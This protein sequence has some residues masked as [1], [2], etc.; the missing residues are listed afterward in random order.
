MALP[1]AYNVRNVRARLRVALLAVGSIA[2]VVAVV[3]VLLAMAQG[4]AAALRGTGRDDNAIVVSRGSNSEV[5]SRVEL[6]ERNAILDHVTAVRGPDGRALASWEWV[7]VMA[8]PRKSDGR[9]SNVVLRMVPPQALQVR[10]GVHVIAGREVQSGLEEVMVGRR[11]VERV[12]GLELGG[13]LEVPALQLKI[14]GVFESEGAASRARSGATTTLLGGRARPGLELA[15][16][17]CRRRRADRR[18]RP[19]DPARQPNMRLRAVSERQY[20]RSRPGPWPRRSRPSA[21]SSRSSRAWARC[22]RR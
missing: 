7:S 3:A 18:A 17:A 13:T 16:G 14:V 4:F 19:L 2:L 6:D 1:L 21:V 10:A 20:S 11:I 22:S 9:R 8:L 12:R 15:R 5:T